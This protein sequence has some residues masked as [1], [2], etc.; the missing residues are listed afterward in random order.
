Y[1]ICH[2]NTT[3]KVVSDDLDF[4]FLNRT[5]KI[6]SW[7]DAKFE[8]LWLYNLHYF[9]YLNSNDCKNNTLKYKNIVES[10]ID[11]NPPCVGNGWEPYP[12]SLR[13]VNWIKF[14]SSSKH[15]DRRNL[16]SLYIQAKVLR[17]TLEYH[18]LGN[19][20][21][22]NAKALIF[23]GSFFSS[24]E[25]NEWLRKGLKILDIEIHEQILKDG[26]N[27]ELSPMYHNIMLADML[28]LYNLAKS[29]VNS[30]LTAKI[31]SWK[32]LIEG[33]ITWSVRMSH[34]DGDVSFFNDSTTGIAPSLDWLLDYSNKLGIK[35]SPIE[36]SGSMS[37]TYLKDSGYLVVV[38]KNIKAILDVGK[39]GPDY[40]PGHAHADTL[41]FEIS[42]FGERVFV[43]SGISEYGLSKERLRQRKTSAHNTVEVDLEDSSEVWGGFRVARRAYPSKV[44]INNTN[45]I[46]SVNCS[47]D[48][49]KRLSGKVTHLRKWSFS[50]NEVCVSDQI[51][52]GFN[53]AISVLHLHPT[54]K[55]EVVSKNEMSLQ[56]SSGNTVLIRFSS[57]FYVEDSTWHPEF[58]LSIPNK[59]IVIDVSNG[60]SDYTIGF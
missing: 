21:F 20:L 50:R 35:L 60:Y 45:N 46:L 30:Q 9:D 11:K 52:G 8:K 15:L 16:D 26:G 7:N 56:L 59:R 28:D 58:G 4:N 57:P 36:N 14:I 42:L 47:H 1:T 12:T 44:K 22:S 31:E 6:E 41:S 40:I 3:A 13:I 55:I 37:H 10:W 27:F 38:D 2:H 34:P 53:S 33:M 19:H 24:P 29:E 48:G 39:I 49:Y 18:L 43:N 17:Q 5:S 51:I 23:A 32:V 25:S 54:V